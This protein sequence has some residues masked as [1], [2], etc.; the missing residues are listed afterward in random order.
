MS[1]A[2]PSTTM[3]VNLLRSSTNRAGTKLAA[4]A[5]SAGP[6]QTASST[7]A[8]EYK[9]SHPKRRPPPLPSID[10]P[11]WSAQEAVN[12]ILYNSESSVLLVV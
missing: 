8:Q 2:F 7:W 3:S 9:L 6:H 11:Q 5:Y 12:N 1:I 10:P 4:R